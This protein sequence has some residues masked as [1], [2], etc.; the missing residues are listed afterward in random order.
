[1]IH[2]GIDENH[3]E[4]RE[5][6]QDIKEYFSKSDDIITAK[7]NIIKIIEQNGKKVVV[8]SFKIPN[9]I[10]KFAYRFI[11][12]SKAKRSFL[13]AK[14]LVKLGINTPEPISYI[15]FFNPLLK[16]SFYICEYFDYDFEI[17]DVLKDENFK[18]RDEILKK[19]VTFSYSLHQKGVYHID[20]SPGN[21]LIKIE[22]GEY[23][24]SIVDVNRMKFISFTQSLRFKN[25]SRFSATKEDTTTIAKEYAKIAGIDEEFAIKQLF[26]Y[27]DKHQQ[28]LKN[29]RKLKKVKEF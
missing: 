11:R 22:D 19:F 2:V 24:F 4:F 18:N 21:V 3:K 27:H 28:Y 6:S 15:E 29:K 20:Y 26:F 13:N 17:R 5:F 7:R 16:E 23:H 8:K 1:V 14:E 12:D 10:N 9:L 25:L